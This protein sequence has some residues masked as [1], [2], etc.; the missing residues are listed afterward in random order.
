MDHRKQTRARSRPRYGELW[1]TG[2]CLGLFCSCSPIP[3]DAGWR[4]AA[5]PSRPRARRGH[6]FLLPTR[7]RKR[8]T[9]GAWRQPDQPLQPRPY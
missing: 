8:L 6:G 2:L 4:Q 1:I 5:G 7:L 9:N 3:E